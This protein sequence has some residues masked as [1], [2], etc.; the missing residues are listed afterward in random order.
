MD[1]EKVDKSVKGGI[2]VKNEL[3]VKALDLLAS[4]D[5]KVDLELDDLKLMVD[6]FELEISGDVSLNI[7]TKE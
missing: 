2:E 6:D 7:R 1:D 5:Q 3:L 4:L